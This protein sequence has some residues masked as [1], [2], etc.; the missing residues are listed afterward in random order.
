MLVNVIAIFFYFI[1]DRVKVIHGIQAPST[2]EANSN[3]NTNN[4]NN[5]VNDN[6]EIENSRLLNTLNWSPVE[7]WIADKPSS[8]AAVGP[9]ND[10]NEP[11]T[12]NVYNAVQISIELQ[13]KMLK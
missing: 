12:K 1:I 10:D 9:T 6:D 2:T 11:K 7:N 3:N 13:K 5:D 4:N 8:S